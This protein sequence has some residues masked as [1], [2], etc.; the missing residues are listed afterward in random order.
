M[1]LPI[2]TGT[3]DKPLKAVIYGPEGV[4]KSTWAAAWPA[5]VF[6]DTEGSTDRLDVA[7]LPAPRVWKELIGY[8]K[9]LVED[10]HQFRTLVID[11][12]DWANKILNED[13]CVERKKA[14]IAAFGYQ[15]GYI[16]AQ[17]RWDELLELCERLRDKRRMNVLF[18]AHAVLRKVEE[19][20]EAGNYDHWEL[21]VDKR[22]AAALK[23]W[24]ELLV[25]AT[26]KLN[27][28]EGTD[29]KKRGIGGRNRVCYTTRCAAYDAKNRFNLPEEMPL[30]FA[31]FAEHIPSLRV[32]RPGPAVK[33]AAPPRDDNDSVPLP[34]RAPTPP[35][36]PKA[37]TAP[38]PAPAATL[39]DPPAP[40][41]APPAPAAP[42][43]PVAGVANSFPASLYDA[44][45]A[46]E[47]TPE[48]AQQFLRDKKLIQPTTT[49]DTLS[50]DF[51][52]KLLLGKN[53]PHFV[54]GC[55]A[56]AKTGKAA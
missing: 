11:T 52:R 14:S 7:R 18:T 47:I 21:N 2:T 38:T 33:P 27:I 3:I 4:G 53:W 25:F 39:V 32:A 34:P 43:E 56:L 49:L 12:A 23:Q 42:A 48:L 45:K 31:A 15:E 26:F 6:I 35:P 55:Q 50:D 17:R 46:A 8:V 22:I 54:A 51:V 30:D 9:G 13:L 5:A 1:A 41:V 10:P 37:A 20:T 40:Y 28:V 44:L 36:P 16:E 29:K 24:A 19:P